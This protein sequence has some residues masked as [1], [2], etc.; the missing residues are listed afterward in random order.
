MSHSIDHR[1]AK[2]AEPTDSLFDVMAEKS[3]IAYC[4]TWGLI[5][6]DSQIKDEGRQLKWREL[7]ENRKMAWTA[8]ARTAWACVALAGGAKAR[9]IET[10]KG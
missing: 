5:R 2:L 9:K 6:T 1:G 7:S 3:Y 8:A 4:E 10:K